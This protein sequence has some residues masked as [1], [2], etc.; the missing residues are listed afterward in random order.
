MEA[1][2]QPATETDAVNAWRTLQLLDAG[3]APQHADLLAALPHVD[4]E[5][6]RR[7]IRNGCVEDIATNILA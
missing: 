2:E 3:Y 5:Q 6:A 4:L 1:D 7:L